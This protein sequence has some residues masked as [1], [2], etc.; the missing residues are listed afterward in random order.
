M[1]ERNEER[2][3][4]NRRDDQPARLPIQ[5]EHRA[6]DPSRRQGAGRIPGSSLARAGEAI[7]LELSL[8]ANDA[9]GCCAEGTWCELTPLGRITERCEKTGEIFEPMD[10]GKSLGE[11]GVSMIAM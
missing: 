6:R 2:I 3:R 5:G 9:S 1:I 11:H 10:A 8:P 7:P 4:I